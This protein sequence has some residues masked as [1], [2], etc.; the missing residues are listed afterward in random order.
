MG[1]LKTYFPERMVK[2]Q[3]RISILKEGLIHINANTTRTFGLLKAE[4]CVFSFDADDLRIG[5]KF[6]EKKCRGGIKIVVRKNDVIRIS[7][8]QFLRRT[9]IEHEKSMQYEFEF[10]EK[11]KN[12]FVIHIDKKCLVGYKKERELIEKLNPNLV[13]LRGLELKD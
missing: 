1:V 5:L 9:G 4:Y 11:E 13:H 2:S 10:D 8:R 7:M 6:H 12:M 3:P